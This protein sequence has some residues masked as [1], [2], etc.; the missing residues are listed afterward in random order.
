MCG[1]ALTWE[2][3][4]L[5]TQTY[6]TTQFA[7]R[8]PQDETVYLE[9]L[10]ALLNDSI[11]LRL[12]S[13]VPVGAFLSGGVDSNGIVALASIQLDRPLQTF[14]VGFGEP[15]FDELAIARCTAE[16]YN[17]DHHEIIVTDTDLSIFSEL[18]EHFDE[19]FGD[20]SMLP[21][22]YIAREARRFV[23]VCLSGDAGD[24]LFAGYPHYREALAY[25]KVDRLPFPLRRAVFGSLA[26]IL[27]DHISGKGL[28]S[29][30]STSP[31]S[32]YQRQIGV[33]DF[34]ERQRLLRPEIAQGNC[35]DARLFEEYFAQPGRD[36]LSTYQLVDQKT[37]L[38]EDV[39]VKVDRA[40]MRSALE[41]RIPF[42]DHRLAEL[43]NAMP[44]QLKLRGRTQKYILRQLLQPVVPPEVL[45]APKRGFGIP[46]KHWFRNGLKS[47]ARELLL[48]PSSRSGR[49][50]QPSSVENLLASHDRGGRDLS[51]RIWALLV[52]EQWCRCF[53]V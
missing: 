15:D 11:R 19:P 18:V 44:A 16:R 30:L 10:R 9:E 38:P 53:R 37:Y 52:L 36:P 21:T 8:P 7:T 41:V 27:P 47:F 5:T 12:R 22:Y 2:K 50:L 51:D 3:G 25:A 23:K 6:W 40:A 1:S 46:I 24:E 49:F 34:H 43:V 42:L 14:S 28:L 35:H 48:S 31:A 32:R 29:R 17:T 13:D 39:L 20:Q 33:F 4:R 26:A 45:T